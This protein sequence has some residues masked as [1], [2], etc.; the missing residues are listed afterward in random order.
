MLSKGQREREAERGG[1]EC[2]RF[3]VYINKCVPLDE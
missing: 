3:I 2:K 1:R